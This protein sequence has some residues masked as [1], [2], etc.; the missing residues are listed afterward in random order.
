[1]QAQQVRGR[2]AGAAGEKAGRRRS[3]YEDRVQ[4]EQVRRQGVDA[5]GERARCRR[6]R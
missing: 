5:T 2:G 4:A 6:C 1:M 3:R